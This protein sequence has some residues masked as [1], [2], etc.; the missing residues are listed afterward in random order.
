MVQLAQLASVA[1]ENARLYQEPRDND[2]RKDEFLAM[3]A[4]ELRNP[5]AAINTSVQLAE[6]GV[7]RADLDSSLGVIARQSRNLSRLIDDLLD[8]SRIS[9][10]KIDLR[11]DMVDLAPILESA[12]EVDRPASGP[13][14]TRPG[15]SRSWSTCWSTSPSTARTAARSA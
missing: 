6:E 12:V 7:G 13:Q 4:H 3:L 8:V 5:L 10:G 14:P 1:L 15:W 2:A 11:L 9:R